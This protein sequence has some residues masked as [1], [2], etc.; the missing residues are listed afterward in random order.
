MKVEESLEQEKRSKMELDKIK[1]KIQQ[2]NKLLQ[3][4]LAE[5]DR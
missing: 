2:D 5:R 3:E 1:R 4:L